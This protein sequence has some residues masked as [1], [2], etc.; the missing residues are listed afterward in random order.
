M[1]SFFNTKPHDKHFS[2]VACVKHFSPFKH[3][4]IVACVKH[5]SPFK[6]F[7]IVACVKHVSPFKH[8]SIVACVKHVSPFKHFSIVACIFSKK[9][10][11]SWYEYDK[12]LCWGLTVLILSTFYSFLLFIMIVIV[13]LL[14]FYINLKMSFKM[15]LSLCSNVFDVCDFFICITV[16]FVSVC[17]TLICYSK[18]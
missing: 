11:N 16:M 10:V 8:F 12:T 5:V 4:S 17:D 15:F 18:Q 14:Y 3:L 13:N 2:I 6:H 9:Q 1:P 7:S